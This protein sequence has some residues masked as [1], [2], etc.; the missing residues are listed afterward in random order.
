MAAIFPFP[1]SLCLTQS[2]KGKRKNLSSFLFLTVQKNAY[3][4]LAFASFT[5]ATKNNPVSGILIA[6][7]IAVTWLP[8]SGSP[9]ESSKI[10]PTAAIAAIHEQ[11]RNKPLLGVIVF[12][13]TP[14]YT[15]GFTA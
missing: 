10:E 2:E 1:A 15:T 8:K 14:P 9:E 4:K 13:N 3:L 5:A 6:R 11:A 12:T 7:I